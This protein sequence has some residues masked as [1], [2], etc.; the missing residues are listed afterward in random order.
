M[1]ALLVVVD[2][3]KDFVT[4]ALGTPQAQAIVERVAARARAGV[5]RG[6]DV[7]FTLDTHGPDYLRTQEGRKLPVAHCI[8]GTDG[9]R[10]VDALEDIPGRRYEK[11]AFG[12][13]ELMRDAAQTGYDRVELVGVC[14]DICVLSNAMLL[15]AA[16]P[17]A[18]I[19]VDAAC[20]AGTT[21]ENHRR[22]LE[23]MAVCQI[24]CENA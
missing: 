16:L 7:V 9:W 3:Q 8:R 17:E 13:V 21:V 6:E 20:C 15:K 2:M 19:V 12:C 5:A 18:E 23:A 22:A 24:R 1:K 14:T 11:P 4:D 10:L